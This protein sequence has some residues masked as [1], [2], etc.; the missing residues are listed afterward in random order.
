MWMEGLGGGKEQ[1]I[2]AKGARSFEGKQTPRCLCFFLG[3]VFINNNQRIRCTLCRSTNPSC[4]QNNHG[5]GSCQR[6]ATS[7]DVVHPLGSLLPCPSRRETAA[8]S[9]P[10]RSAAAQFTRQAVGKGASAQIPARVKRAV[11]AVTGLCSE[12]ALWGGCS[13]VTLP[14]N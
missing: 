7:R 10:V 14:Q 4:V 6:G 3:C 8:E 2:Q 12:P 9:P 5:R 11:I 1:P 13:Y